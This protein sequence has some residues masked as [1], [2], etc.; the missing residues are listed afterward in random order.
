MVSSLFYNKLNLGPSSSK[1]TWFCSEKC[2]L[3]VKETSCCCFWHNECCSNDAT[4]SSSLNIEV[5]LLASQLNHTFSSLFC[6]SSV[7]RPVVEEVRAVVGLV[8]ERWGLQFSTDGWWLGVDL[9]WKEFWS[10]VQWSLVSSL[11]FEMVLKKM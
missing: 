8:G 9:R 7:L 1:L 10:Q 4:N 3:F 2:D 6:E 5:D 11:W